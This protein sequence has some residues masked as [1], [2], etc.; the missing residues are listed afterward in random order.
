MG[1][2][3]F[4][5][6]RQDRRCSSREP[7]PPRP[8][9][10]A[11]FLCACLQKIFR[12]LLTLQ[13][14]EFLESFHA[15]RFRRAPAWSKTGPRPGRNFQERRSRY[16]VREIGSRYCPVALDRRWDLLRIA[17]SPQPGKER[18]HPR[19]SPRASDAAVFREYSTTLLTKWMGL[20]VTLLG[21]VVKAYMVKSDAG[22]RGEAHRRG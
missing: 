15:P 7:C 14:L 1:P 12:S 6:N 2:Q 11:R 4:G 19:S 8:P 5:L 17:A 10:P 9:A 3:R 16:E 21:Q 18:I 22:Q 13:V 20:A